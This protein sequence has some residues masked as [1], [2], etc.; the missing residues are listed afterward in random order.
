M[1]V[2]VFKHQKWAEF[3]TAD[4]IE[5]NTHT[6]CSNRAESPCRWGDC[7]CTLFCLCASS[8]CW[9]QISLNLNFSFVWTK[10]YSKPPTA[11]AACTEFAAVQYAVLIHSSYGL[12]VTVFSLEVDV[13][14]V[15]GSPLAGLMFIFAFLEMKKTGWAWPFSVK[16]NNHPLASDTFLNVHKKGCICP[17]WKLNCLPGHG[18]KWR[19]RPK[20]TVQVPFVLHLN[21]RKNHV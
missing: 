14:G 1:F 11:P 2:L 5:E 9:R 12:C 4:E 21:Q 7:L 6:Q 19:N 10:M 18:S 13:G 16:Q 15:S 8:D 20:M 3:N 17:D